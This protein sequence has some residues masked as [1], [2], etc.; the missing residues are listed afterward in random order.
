MN[1]EQIRAEYIDHL[2]SDLMVVNAA[3]TSFGKE[4]DWV[5]GSTLRSYIPYYPVSWAA[6]C[7]E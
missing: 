7:G 5:P 6:L 3:R 1:V 4:S 2:G